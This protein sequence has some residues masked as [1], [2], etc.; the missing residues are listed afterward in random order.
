[1][2]ANG[3][4]DRHLHYDDIRT[5]VREIAPADAEALLLNRYERQRKLDGKHVEF[6]A[7]CMRRGEFKPSGIEV[8]HLRLD[9]EEAEYVTD[10][11]HR[12]QAI[13]A[14]GKPVCLSITRFY[15]SDPATIDLA[16][17]RTQGGKTPSTN[18]RLRALGGAT[19][20]YGFNERERSALGV[21]SL[22]LT[23]SLYDYGTEHLSRYHRTAEYRMRGVAFWAAEGR[24]FLDTIRGAPNRVTTKLIS[25]PVLGLGLVTF[26]YQP[27]RA[28][29]FWRQVAWQEGLVKD[30]PLWKAAMLLQVQ[31]RPIGVNVYARK[32]A[33][34]WNAWYADTP[35]LRNLIVKNERAPIRIAGTPFKG[36][37]HLHF[38]YDSPV[39]PLFG[40]IAELEKDTDA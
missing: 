15:T 39:N 12:L 32:L 4:N 34:C 35:S 21:A 40:L 10:G 7:D 27:E 24:M 17:A 14:A 18:D 3:S 13:L 37:Q 38:D 23:D 5:E 20:S 31:Q 8:H 6:L 9:G 33:A 1:M 2:N 11:Q 29:E 25:S 19:G 28:A 16:Y 36:H 26:R 22:A 30:T